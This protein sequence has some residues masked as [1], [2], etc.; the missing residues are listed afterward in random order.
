VTISGNRTYAVTEVF[1]FVNETA[2]GKPFALTGDFNVLPDSDG[3]RFLTGQ[4]EIGGTCKSWQD[5]PEEVLERRRID[6][7]FVSQ[8]VE[9]RGIRLA[10]ERPSAAGVYPSD[11][12]GLVTDLEPL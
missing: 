12:L 2:S 7:V 5:S 6:Y 9:V 4:I 10:G 8:D 11:H 3:V 1:S